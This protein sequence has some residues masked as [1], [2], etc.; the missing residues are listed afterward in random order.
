MTKLTIIKVG[1]QVIDDAQRLNEL[2]TSFAALPHPKILVHGGGKRAS[3]IS[4]AM[5]IEPQLVDGRRLTDAATLE[6]VTMVYAGLINKNVVA[7]LQA[8]DCPSMGLSGADANFILAHKRPV[9]K[10]DYGYAGDVDHVNATHIKALLSLGNALVFCPIT[11]DGKGQLLNTNADTIATELAVACSD[12]F[13]IEIRYCFER[14]GVL[15]NSEDDTS[16]IDILPKQAYN[17]LLKE[18]AVHSGM[19]PKLDNAF[20]AKGRGLTR[21][22][23]GDWKL[24]SSGTEI[25]EA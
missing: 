22:V 1:G 9:G 15:L 18:G 12:I 14:P 5:G 24:A 23:V 3:T 11:H 8:L 20:K 10:I 13:D 21:V 25:I 7:Q 16:I 17:H 4:K 6:V 19:I 2:L